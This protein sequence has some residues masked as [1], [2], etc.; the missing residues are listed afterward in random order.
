M[1]HQSLLFA[2]QQ[3]MQLKKKS[4]LWAAKAILTSLLFLQISTGLPVR[5]SDD[6]VIRGM[7]SMEAGKP[8]PTSTP[9][10]K[11]WGKL[12]KEMQRFINRLRTDQALRDQLLTKDANTV[13]IAK[14]YG[15]EIDSYQI[16]FQ[17]MIGDN[18][19]SMDE[20]EVDNDLA[21]HFSTQPDI[22][23][24][25]RLFYASYSSL[26]GKSS[27]LRVYFYQVSDFVEEP[28]CSWGWTLG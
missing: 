2:E 25:S 15:F 20:L 11:N 7:C 16:V 3:I 14:R 4:K 23:P 17:A 28:C 6:A 9:N 21:T 1:I 22:K 27:D 26:D 10:G 18:P 19:E 8:A 13:A 12:E 5:A 24:G